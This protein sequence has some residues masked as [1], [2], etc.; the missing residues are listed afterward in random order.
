[1]M[2]FGIECGDGWYDILSAL[3]FG[4]AQHERNVLAARKNLNVSLTGATEEYQPVR[5]DQ[6]KEKFGACGSITTAAT[7][8]CAA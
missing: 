1:M 7:S 5:F 8:M 4:I 6:I 3:C 2:G